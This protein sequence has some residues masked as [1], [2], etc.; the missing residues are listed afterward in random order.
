MFPI[1]DSSGRVIAFS[2]RIFISETDTNK[3]KVEE[4]KYLNSP[5]T[6]LFNKSNVLFGID[7]AKTEIRKR[8]YT[9]VV[10]GQMDLILSHQAGFINTVAVSGTALADNVTDHEAKINNLGLITDEIANI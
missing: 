4:A 5:D 10:E 1:S 8:G 7:K 3:P 9:I 2:G 6:P